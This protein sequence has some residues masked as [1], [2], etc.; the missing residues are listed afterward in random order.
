M[1]NVL[2]PDLKTAAPAATGSL[3]PGIG[4]RIA[5]VLGLTLLSVL[6]IGGLLNGVLSGESLRRLRSADLG[7]VRW[8]MLAA[9]LAVH[10]AGLGFEAVQLK[11]L[12]AAI[13]KPARFRQMLRV[14]LVGNVVAQI[15]PSALGGEPAQLYVMSR[16]GYALA[17]SSFLL[18]LRAFFSVAAR[19]VLIIGFGLAAV[20]SRS[21]PKSPAWNI[22]AAVTAAAMILFFVALFLFFFT[23]RI[24]SWVTRMAGKFPLLV[25]LFRCR[26]EDEFREKCG[27]FALQFRALM[28]TVFRDKRKALAGGF[29]IALFSWISAKSVPFFIMKAF[30]ESPSWPVVVAAGIIAQIAAGW[31]P[32]PGAVGAAEAAMAAFFFPLVVRGDPAVLIPLFVLLF[33]FF[34]FP[35]N[36]LITIPLVPRLFRG[37]TKTAPVSE[38]VSA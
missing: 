36:V 3:L 16:D 18:T 6:L 11:L 37:K 27:R 26:T 9:A 20:P 35:L 21:W 14:Y 17:E 38:G 13:G 7:S 25:R 12:S 2:S 4:R 29:L 28:I 24:R 1:N 32:T 15:T 10:L 19:V 34:E 33:R 22:L 31:A 5:L 8:T 30:G 23:A